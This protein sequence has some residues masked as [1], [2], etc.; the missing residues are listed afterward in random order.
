MHWPTSIC[1]FKRADSTTVEGYFSTNLESVRKD[2]ECTF[3]I[4]KKRWRT[5]NNGLMYC[6]ITVCDQNFVTCCCLHNFLLDVMVRERNM[7]V[8]WGYPIG[9]DGLWLDGNTLVEEETERHLAT[10]FGQ[11]RSLLATHLQVFCQKGPITEEE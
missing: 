4:L 8:G 10:R 7:R 1:P 2:V 11:R 6:D 5:L 3:V 9:A